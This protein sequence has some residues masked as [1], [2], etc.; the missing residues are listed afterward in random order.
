ME[1]DS[2]R[3]QTKPCAHQDQQETE[4]D[5]RVNVPESPA[6]AQIHS[7][8]HWL[9]QFWEPRLLAYVLLKEAA[10]TA[11]NPTI[12]GLSPN[13]QEYNPTQ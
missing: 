13:L 12:D 10:I 1:T 5:M 7:Q 6:E 3:A 4:P 8:G 9:Q 2:W 11:I